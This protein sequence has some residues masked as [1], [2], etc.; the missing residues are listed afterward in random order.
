[1]PPYFLQPLNPR[2]VYFLIK[3]TCISI[4]LK[5]DRAIALIAIKTPFYKTKLASKFILASQLLN[6]Y[7]IISY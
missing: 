1:V 5:E 6:F 3:V 4:F 7:L 2:H